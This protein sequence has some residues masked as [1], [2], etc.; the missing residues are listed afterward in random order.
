MSRI[1]LL[2]A[3]SAGI[4]SGC[5]KS[6]EGIEAIYI[7]P[8]P[9]ENKDCRR[10]DAELERVAIALAKAT[11]RQHQAQVYDLLGTTAFGKPI[12]TLSGDTAYAQIAELKGREKALDQA[13]KRKD[14]GIYAH[15]M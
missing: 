10:L 14:C 9:Y 2:A 3:L 11:E 15:M 6:P 13:M 4:L 5:A 1:F 12:S 7:S 8:I